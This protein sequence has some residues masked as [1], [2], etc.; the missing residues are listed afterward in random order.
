M[1]KLKT[2]IFILLFACFATANAQTNAY[3]FKR[4]ITGVNSLWHSMK[5][6][7]GLY[8]NANAG[9]EDLRIFGIKGKDTLEVPYLLKQRA[10]QIISKEIDFKPV[11]ES[12]N[13]NGYY[14]TF[15]LKNVTEINQINLAFKE[16]NFNWDVTLEG[17]NSNSEWF[18]ILKDY[19]ILSIK[20]K[21]TD[22]QFTKLSFPDSKYQYL[23]LM[24]KSPVKPGLLEAL[25]N[26]TDTVKGTYQDV[27]Y[28]TFKLKN[29]TVDKETVIDVA[30]ENPVPLSYL[31]LNAQSHFDFFRPIKIEYA[32]DSFKTDKGMQYNYAPL[33]EGNISS[34]EKSEFNFQNT[35]ASK[36]KI[37]I[38]NND[39][40][41]LR[42]NGLAL[43]GNLYEIIAR[44]DNPTLTYAL[45]YGNENVTAPSYEIEKFENE[46]PSILTAV[47]IGNQKENLAYS[48]K[49]EKPLFENK[50]WLWALMAVIIALLGWFS[51]KMLKN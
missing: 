46:I 20:N 16:A 17:S 45:Y 42:L 14:Y 19:R 44:F 33:F 24:I 23:R 32:T 43:K 38:Q 13:A 50:T 36:L 11:N 22:Y 37:T 35:I 31:K 9:F 10:D 30:L 27:K 8:K 12:A 34:L 3:K 4:E 49:I 18:T 39:N 6:P 51:Y 29:N 47:T 21:D 40:K 15:E 26:K 28:K 48:I 5:L 41:P 1:L 2:N 7:D 25:I